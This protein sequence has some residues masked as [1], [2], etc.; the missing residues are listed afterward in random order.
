MPCGNSYNNYSLTSQFLCVKRFGNICIER[1]LRAVL[2]VSGRTVLFICFCYTS[3]ISLYPTRKASGICK[4]SCLSVFVKLARL[5]REW[6][7][8]FCA[9]ARMRWKLRRPDWLAEFGQRCQVLFTPWFP[10]AFA[11]AAEGVKNRLHLNSSHRC[12]ISTKG[13]KACLHRPCFWLY[14]TNAYIN[15]KTSIKT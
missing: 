12:Y 11:I 13:V 5:K 9:N 8:V 4:L 14:S 2:L 3:S 1:N 15:I 10:T 6:S 7:T